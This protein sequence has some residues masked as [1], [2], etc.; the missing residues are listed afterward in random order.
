MDPATRS[1]PF[2]AG[3]LLVVLAAAFSAA[4]LA[5]PW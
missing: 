4:P 3:W 2:R 5:V 1:S